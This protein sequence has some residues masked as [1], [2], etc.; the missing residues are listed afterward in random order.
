MNI[1]L[2]T[3]IFFPDVIG[4]SGRVVNEIGK[5]LVRQG[6]N[7]YVLTPRTNMNLPQQANIE[8]IRIYRYNVNSRN[9]VTFVVSSLM[10]TLFPHFM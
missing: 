2:V 8:G 3:D 5:G 4:G 6:H 1:L 10:S 9:S 7:V